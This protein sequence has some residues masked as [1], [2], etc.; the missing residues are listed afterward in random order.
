MGSPRR[1]VKTRLDRYEIFLGDNV[2]LLGNPTAGLCMGGIAY[3]SHYCRILNLLGFDPTNR[4]V[5]GLPTLLFSPVP[6]LL[7]G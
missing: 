4:F 1:Q 5:L 6:A 3:D 2:L 7:R